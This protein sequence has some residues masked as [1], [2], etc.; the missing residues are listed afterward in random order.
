MNSRRG[1]TVLTAF[2]GAAVRVRITEEA[3]GGIIFTKIV[4]LLRPRQ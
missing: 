3:T 2:D 4:E 1:L